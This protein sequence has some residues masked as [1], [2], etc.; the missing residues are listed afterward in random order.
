MIETLL[1]E[2]LELKAQ[3]DALKQKKDELGSI[4]KAELNKTENKRFL[5]ENYDAK[6]VSKKTF[7]YTNESEI[8]KLLKDKYNGLF[9]TETINTKS[10]NTELKNKPEFK[11]LFKTYL[12][13]TDSDTLSVLKVGE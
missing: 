12:T 7:K 11:D 10:F 8:L 2:Y 9:I 5:N 1:K 13:E 4:I 6:I 3:E